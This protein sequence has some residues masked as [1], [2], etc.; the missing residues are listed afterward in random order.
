MMNRQSKAI[1][2]WYGSINTISN[3]VMDSLVSISVRS[4]PPTI[5]KR[6]CDIASYPLLYIWHVYDVHWPEIHDVIYTSRV[7]QPFH[8]VTSGY[9]SERK[10]MHWVYVCPR[11]IEF[12]GFWDNLSMFNTLR[13]RQNGRH[14]ADDIFKWILLNENVW[15]PIKISLKFV[16]KGLINNIPS[17]V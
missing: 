9:L 8:H 3:G 14:F 5:P 6:K 15:F 17:L 11:K 12:M 13:P 16:P 10:A 1:C 4:S 2:N 7:K